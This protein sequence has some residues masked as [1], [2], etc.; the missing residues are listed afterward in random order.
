MA[1]AKQK[2]IDLPNDLKGECADTYQAFQKLDG[3]DFDN[4]YLLFNVKD[5]L[6]DIMMFRNEAQSGTDAD[7]KAWAAKTLPNLQKHAGHIGQVAR[8]A[9]LPIETLTGSGVAGGSS[10]D[11]ARPAGGRIEGTQGG[12]GTGTGGTRTPSS[13]NDRLNPKTGSSGQGTNR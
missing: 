10:G 6:K 8:S 2:N 5:H 12:S 4:A 9:G 11:T 13:D 3:K 1:V 7:V